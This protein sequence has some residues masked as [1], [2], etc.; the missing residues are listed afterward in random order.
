M[1]YC[2]QWGGALS[3]CSTP[4]EHEHWALWS[5]VVGTGPRLAENRLRGESTLWGSHQSPCLPFSFHGDEREFSL[6]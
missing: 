3:T 4:P 5:G 1:P 6:D 2:A